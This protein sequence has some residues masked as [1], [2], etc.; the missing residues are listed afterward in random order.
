MASTI[1]LNFLY[2]KEKYITK[3]QLPFSEEKVEI[4]S[5]VYKYD[6]L[7]D[8]FA[9]N[10]E[11]FVFSLTLYSEYDQCEFKFYVNKGENKAYIG[12]DA[13]F[14]TV[15]QLIIQSKENHQITQAHTK[16]EKLDSLGNKYRKRLTLINIDSQ[17]IID[18]E[19]VQLNNI[20]KMNYDLGK[21]TN[22]FF[23]ISA[24]IE[25]EKNISELKK[26][27][28]VKK[29]EDKKENNF[30]ENIK[31]IKSRF[32]DFMEHLENVVKNENFVMNYE[33]LVKTYK[34]IFKFELPILNK[35]SSYMNKAYKDNNLTDLSDFFNIFFVKYIFNNNYIPDQKFLTNI[36][37]K[38]KNACSDIEFNNSIEIDEKIKILST[39]LLVYNECETLDKLNSLTVKHFIFSDR[40]ENSIMDKVYK[41]YEKF[42]EDISE[43]NDVFSYLLQLN[44][45]IG[46]F[47]KNKVYTFDL[48]NIDMIKN[49]LKALFPKS[50]T[51]YNFNDKKEHDHIAFV[52]AHTGGIAL[53]EYFL[54]LNKELKDIDYNS[55]SQNISGKDSDEIAMNIVIFLFHEYLGHK[56]FHISED[57]SCSPK[58]IVRNNQLIELKYENLFE[59]TD[60]NSE[61]ILTSFSNRRDSG[62]FLELCYKKFNNK[63]IFKILA[64][65]KDKGKL[66]RRPDLFI[67]KIETI[68]NYTI[69]KKIAEEKNISLKFEKNLSIEEEIKEMNLQIDIQKYMEEQKEKEKIE[70]KKIVKKKKKKN[71]YY[72]PLKTKEGET[73]E[74]Y[75]VQTQKEEVSNSS[76]ICEENEEIKEYEEL[77][78]LKD[79]KM[80]RILRKFKFKYDEDLQ[81]NVEKKMEEPNLTLE[82]YGDLDYL[83]KKFMK[84]Y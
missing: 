33:N 77:K 15:Y 14:R 2:F 25:K 61:Y 43:D 9:Y 8:Y 16:F 56:K 55:N 29:I 50:L 30:L 12:L 7:N 73:S 18:R 67:G 23:Q 40:K 68:E 46:F 52:A 79:E 20:V 39:K 3:F 57:G 45:G 63:L 75:S 13:F 1:E 47:K 66:I 59:K 21:S 17:I 54:V 53:D 5:D 78:Y 37:E 19:V 58:K 83:Y 84:L 4:K 62:Y 32:K 26:Q 74:E 51:I 42:I 49:H 27:F 65:L 10:K 36:L 31:N 48:T 22:D 28:I 81:F 72:L 82:D 69:L 35:D 24:L 80:K 64:T 44:S 38:A 34:D 60:E 6:L 11:K 70:E 76:E 71:Q 41:F